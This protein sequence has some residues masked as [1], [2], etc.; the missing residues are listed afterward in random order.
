M[1]LIN[2]IQITYK[3]TRHPIRCNCN[4]MSLHRCWLF[5]GGGSGGGAALQNLGEFEIVRET[6]DLDLKSRQGTEC[7]K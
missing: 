1:L 6:L 3:I 2:V 7:A 4:V 5:G